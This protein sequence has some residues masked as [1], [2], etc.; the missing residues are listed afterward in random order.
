MT[1]L[2]S[3]FVAFTT[4]CATEDA[5]NCY[6]NAA[7]HGNNTGQSFVDVNGTAYYFDIP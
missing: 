2:F 1:F 5:Q 3:L 7:E 6:W 4:P